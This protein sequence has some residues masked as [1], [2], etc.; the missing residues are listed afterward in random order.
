MVVNSEPFVNGS[1]QHFCYSYI[2]YGECPITHVISF[3]KVYMKIFIFWF[4]AYYAYNLDTQKDRLKIIIIIII[5]FRVL[6]FFL[7]V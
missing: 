1:M 4:S 2:S 6:D 3:N 5:L 7:S